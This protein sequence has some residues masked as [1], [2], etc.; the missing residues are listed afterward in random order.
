MDIPA[1]G[2][3]PDTTQT[4]VCVFVFYRE[5]LTLLSRFVSSDVDCTEDVTEDTN[6]HLDGFTIIRSDRDAT[7][8]R[9]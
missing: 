2:A 4:R 8:T 5:V 7:R 9:K 3:T 6:F 1:L